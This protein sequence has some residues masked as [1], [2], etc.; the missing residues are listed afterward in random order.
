[1]MVSSRVSQD[2]PSAAVPADFLLEQLPRLQGAAEIKLALY[3]YW[4]RSQHAEGPLVLTASQLHEDPWL[5]RSL[6]GANQPVGDELQQALEALEQHGVIVR[7]SKA[8]SAY[9]VLADAAGQAAL[10]AHAR[11]EW[12]PA[13]ST[14]GE[15]ERARRNIFVLYEQNFGPLTPLLAERLIETEAEFPQDWIREA[16]GLALE[17]NVR[18]WRY[19]QAIL[20]GWKDQ[21]RHERDDRG[22]P[23][24]ARRKYIQ[25]EFSDHIK[26]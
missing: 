24:E 5:A 1:M 16:M 9:Y 7:L 15:L 12:T 25:G 4:H 26:H 19:V 20:D 2:S 23:E 14:T 18:K 8:E 10:Q 17:N 13:A 21:G 11:G 6:D 22:R 3:F